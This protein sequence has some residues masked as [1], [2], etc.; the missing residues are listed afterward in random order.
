[1]RSFLYG[2]WDDEKWAQTMAKDMFA[3]TLGTFIGSAYGGGTVFEPIKNYVLQ[4]PYGQS[5]EHPVL[6]SFG[7]LLKGVGQVGTGKF[8]SGLYNI[9]NTAFKTYGLPTTPLTV[10]KKVTGGISS[11]V[12]SEE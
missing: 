9:T 7:Q 5:I 12:S 4:R 10:G 11:L 1:M 3:D 8:G 2:G 6:Q